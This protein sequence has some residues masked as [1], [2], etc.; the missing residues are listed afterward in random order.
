[1]PP[2]FRALLAAPGLYAQDV[3]GEKLALESESRLNDDA[4]LLEKGASIVSAEVIE[5]SP[6]TELVL[7]GNAE[8]RHA[9]S[10][11]QS[12]PHHLHAGYR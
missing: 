5:G 2:P 9:G 4:A 11:V 7:S 10:V 6:Q 12:R 1:M 8:V 3:S